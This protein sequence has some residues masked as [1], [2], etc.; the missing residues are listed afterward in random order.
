MDVNDVVGL[1]TKS[2]PKSIETKNTSQFSLQKFQMLLLFSHMNAI[3][4]ID[5]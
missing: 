3:I 5:G 4:D 1:F 2:I